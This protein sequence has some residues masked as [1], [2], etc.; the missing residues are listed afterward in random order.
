MKRSRAPCL[1]RIKSL[2]DNL[3]ASDA[4]LKSM[5]PPV[6][7]LSICVILDIQ[8]R[9][10]C[11]FGRFGGLFRRFRLVFVDLNESMVVGLAFL[12]RS[13]KVEVFAHR[14]LISGPF[15]WG[16]AT[17]V[18]LII[19]VNNLFDLFFFRGVF[20]KNWLLLF[21]FIYFFLRF[22]LHFNTFYTLR[23]QFLRIFRVRCF[24][25]LTLTCLL[26][27]LLP[28]CRNTQICYYFSD[29]FTLA[30]VNLTNCA[31]VVFWFLLLLHLFPKLLHH[32]REHRRGGLLP[33][34]LLCN[35][36]IVCL[37]NAC[38]IS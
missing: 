34:S 14:T 31:K 26:L 1:R 21:E 25:G 7:N 11:S 38:P 18:T 19:C 9:V 17:P 33:M 16:N 22:W 3:L 12:A 8:K 2:H 27:L 30:Q 32:I 6:H 28:P 36:Q 10:K 13:T 37:K 35:R 24:C 15:D 4:L 5:D 29:L 23:R 20:I